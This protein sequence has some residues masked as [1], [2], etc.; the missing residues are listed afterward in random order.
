MLFM[1]PEQD[2][3]TGLRCQEDF[4]SAHASVHPANQR[5]S[6]RDRPFP[7]KNH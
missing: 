7:E 2:D 6:K 3:L 4:F 5:G 1:R